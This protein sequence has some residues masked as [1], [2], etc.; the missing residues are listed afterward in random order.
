MEN[1]P[2]M[3]MYFLLKMKL[4][5]YCHLTFYIPQEKPWHDFFFTRRSYAESLLG[6]HRLCW[7]LNHAGWIGSLSSSAHDHLRLL[8]QASGGPSAVDVDLPPIGGLGVMIFFRRMSSIFW[9]EQ[10]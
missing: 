1:G 4:C 3:K 5:H 7:Y 6:D 8:R 2:G 10:T 9:G